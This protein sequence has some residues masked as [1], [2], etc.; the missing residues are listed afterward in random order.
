MKCRKYWPRA[1]LS[2]VSHF[3]LLRI[4]M[5]RSGGSPVGSMAVIFVHD[6]SVLDH[7]LQ[8]VNGRARNTKWLI[9]I[10]STHLPSLPHLLAVV[11]GACGSDFRDD[12]F[13]VCGNLHQLLLSVGHLQP[14]EKE[15]CLLKYPIS[16]QEYVSVLYQLYADSNGRI[17]YM[18]ILFL[19]SDCWSALM[20]DVKQFVKTAAQK[21]TSPTGCTSSMHM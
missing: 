14:G 1:W 13:V 2:T 8:K 12:V 17:T 20:H 9:V 18:G 6:R 3:C 19:H 11:V 21:H 16:V 10:H 15:K 7:W 5:L 4:I